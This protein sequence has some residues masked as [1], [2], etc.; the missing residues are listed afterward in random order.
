VTFTADAGAGDASHGP[1]DEGAVEGV[2]GNRG[3]EAV[4]DDDDGRDAVVGLASL[5]HADRGRMTAQASTTH[6]LNS[7][8]GGVLQHR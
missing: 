2:L 8:I 6:R 4:P 3:R 7:A 1:T 5:L